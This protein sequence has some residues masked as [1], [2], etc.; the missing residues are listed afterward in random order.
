MLPSENI[1]TIPFLE[2]YIE[3]DWVFDFTRIKV[4][5]LQVFTIAL[6]I[7]MYCLIEGKE[8]VYAMYI[9]LD[10]I[11]NVCNLIFFWF[12]YYRDKSDK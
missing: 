6:S 4:Q 11:L 2:H 1:Q 5:I 3:M 10:I 12:Y 8:L 7:T 9:P